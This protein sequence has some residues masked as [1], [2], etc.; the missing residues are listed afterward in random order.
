MSR[1]EFGR[2]TS[3][4]PLATDQVEVNSFSV[5]SGKLAFHRVKTAVLSFEDTDLLKKPGSKGTNFRGFC[6]FTLKPLLF[7]EL[8]G[9]NTGTVNQRVSRPACLNPPRSIVTIETNYP[10]AIT[11]KRRPLE[12]MSGARTPFSLQPELQPRFGRPNPLIPKAAEN[13][14]TCQVVD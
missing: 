14:Q 5:C 6:A 13:M 2:P 1:A 10:F 3:E 11:E 9:K 7:V 12:E 8:R 4:L